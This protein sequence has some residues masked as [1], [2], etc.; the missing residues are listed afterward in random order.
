[1][2]V[3]NLYHYTRTSRIRI[4][5]DRDTTV[6][7]R[8]WNYRGC[9]N[10]AFLIADLSYAQWSFASLSFICSK[11]NSFLVLLVMVRRG[12]R[13]FVLSIVTNSIS[14]KRGIL[15]RAPAT[16]W[17]YRGRKRSNGRTWH[18][19]MQLFF[20]YRVLAAEDE[21]AVHFII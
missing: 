8:S 11:F 18:A 6:I 16:N 20:F 7:K 5:L 9:R 10:G 19:C 21:E 2:F 14:S 13:P 1:M 4:R 15:E 12:H 17:S 3:N